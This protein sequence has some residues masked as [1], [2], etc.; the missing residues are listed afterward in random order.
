MAMSPQDVSGALSGRRVLSVRSHPL[1][2]V[3]IDV[4]EWRRRRRPVKNDTLTEQER[5]FEGSISLFLQT[6][7]T[8]HGTSA[9]L[10]DGRRPEGD[11][12][13]R[14]LDQLV[15]RILLKADFVN[16]LLEL[17][18]AFDNGLVLYVETADSAPGAECYSIA[19]DDLFWIVYGGGRID[20]SHRES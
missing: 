16:P 10:V 12:V 3:I 9:L 19:I 18:L 20:E 5:I 2:G 14:L 4:G 6:A 7:L 1:S 8:L 17:K 13:W 15:G 11:D